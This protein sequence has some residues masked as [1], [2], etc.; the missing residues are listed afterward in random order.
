MKV[1]PGMSGKSG[2][3]IGSG[4]PMASAKSAGSIVGA[5]GVG[6]SLAHTAWRASRWSLQLM[7]ASLTSA[8][9]CALHAFAAAASVR[10]AHFAMASDLSLRASSLQAFNAPCVLALHASL[11]LAGEDLAS[12]LG[13]AEAAV[14]RSSV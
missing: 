2:L 12:I 7:S 9:A 3:V 14:A 6:P 5:Y 1:V 4:L 8:D 13:V 10:F 11:V